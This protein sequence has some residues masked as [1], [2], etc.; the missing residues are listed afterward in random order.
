MRILITGGGTGGHIYPALAIARKSMQLFSEPEILYVG[1]EKGLERKLVLSE[2]I[3]FTTVSARG[4]SRKLN[5]DT[6]YFAR[7]LLKGFYQSIRIIRRFR[8]HIVIGTGGYVCGPVLLAARVLNIP[9]LIHEQNVVPG[10]T[11]RSFARFA[12]C[13]CVSFPESKEF[14]KQF[15]RLEITGNPRAEEILSLTGSAP[16]K[17]NNSELKAK[18]VLIFSGSKGAEKINEVFTQVIPKLLENEA[19]Q[20]V[21]VTGERYYQE[22]LSDLDELLTPKKKEKLKIYPYLENMPAAIISSDLVV[23]RAGAT[24]VAELTA[25]LKPAI[26]IPSPNVADEHQMKNARAMEERGAA[27]VV[28]ENTLQWEKVYHLI[29]ALFQDASQLNQMQHGAK[30]LQF[31]SAATTIC[32]IAAQL[33]KNYQ[34]GRAQNEG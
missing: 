34:Q 19:I 16:K 30:K 21:Y 28:E 32:E 23:S 5:I 24:T 14:F 8:P 6:V 3:N 15:K 18:T 12:D 25:A 9:T 13:T 4:W 7:D 17:E 2:A 1:T 20:V 31:P 11:N 33:V 29:M 27:M 22:T 10:I 26:L